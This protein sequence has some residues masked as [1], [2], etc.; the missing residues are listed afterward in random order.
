MQATYQCKRELL[1]KIKLLCCL[2]FVCGFGVF[3]VTGDKKRWNLNLKGI[4]YF[5]KQ[6]K[7]QT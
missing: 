3:L 4:F 1:T 5:Y 7:Q 6:T 2:G